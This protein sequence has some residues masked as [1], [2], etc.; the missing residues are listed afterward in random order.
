MTTPAHISGEEYA[1]FTEA[2]LLAR[3]NARCRRAY[4]HDLRD[5][6]QGISGAVDLLGRAASAGGENRALLERANDLSRRTI[7]SYEASVAS[8]LEDLL[9]PA[10]AAASLVLG[11]LLQTLSKFLRNDAASKDIALRIAASA[12]ARLVVPRRKLRL[13]ILG[14]L[15]ALIDRLPHGAEIKIVAES[16]GDGV[17]LD[18]SAKVPFGKNVDTASLEGLAVAVARSVLSAQGGRVEIDEPFPGV[19]RL[20]MLQPNGAARA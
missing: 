10:D 5:G 15:T 20:R 8:M 2:A 17:A 12:D 3:V 18:F 6:L 19:H 1:H 13:I 11:D 16:T 9:I 4:L 7:T 14:L